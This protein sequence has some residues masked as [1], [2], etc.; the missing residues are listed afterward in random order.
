MKLYLFMHILQCDVLFSAI[1]ARKI[2]VRHCMPPISTEKDVS[3]HRL[4]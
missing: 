4:L 1:L 2:S 3:S